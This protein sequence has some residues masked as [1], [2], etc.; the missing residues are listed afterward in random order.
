M[1]APAPTAANPSSLY[2]SI[3]TRI[4]TNRVERAKQHQRPLS[5]LPLKQGL[6]PPDAD[7]EKPDAV[8]SLHFH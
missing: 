5:T 4:E 8:L 1:A 2:T 6:K 3:K 7:G